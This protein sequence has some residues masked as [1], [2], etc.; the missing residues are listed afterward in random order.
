MQS[1]GPATT[2][3]NDAARSSKGPLGLLFDLFSN[4]KFGIVLLV[5]LFVYMS[6]GSAGIVYPTHPN[7]LH[8]DAWT[9][10]QMRQWRGLEMT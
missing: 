4:V 6:V 10:A 1:N 2:T 3:G 5:L 8:S 7:L 9:H